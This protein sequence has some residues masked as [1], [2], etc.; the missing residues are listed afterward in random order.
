M[1]EFVRNHT[2][3]LVAAQLLHGAAGDGHHGIARREAGGKG[4]EAGLVVEHVHGRDG[5]ARGNGHLLD[6]VEQAA[7]L[8]VGRVRLQAPTADALG[9]RGTPGAKDGPFVQRTET[10]DGQRAGGDGQQQ[11]RVKPDQL[12]CGVGVLGA[13]EINQPDGRHVAQDDCADHR[14]REQPDEP[15]GSLAG[16]FLGLE[17]VHDR[18]SRAD[19]RSSSVGGPRPSSFAFRLK[20]R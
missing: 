20:R 3:Q 16:A 2:L 11:R 1:A 4:V 10:D 6:D 17:E 15:G 19:G 13:P 5:H 8:E 12:I 14:Q 7:F 18:K 9:D